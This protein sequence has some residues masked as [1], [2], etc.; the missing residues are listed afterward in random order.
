MGLPVE[1][2]AVGNDTGAVVVG[3]DVGVI[4]VG[5]DEGGCEFLG[6]GGGGVGAA[7]SA[8]FHREFKTRAIPKIA[9][10]NFMLK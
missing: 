4:V 8:T 1:G 9:V 7:A 10:T 2:D 5:A 6:G 3:K